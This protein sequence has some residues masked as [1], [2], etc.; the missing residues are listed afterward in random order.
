MSIEAAQQ[1]IGAPTFGSDAQ[2][3]QTF[4]GLRDGLYRLG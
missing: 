3:L 1:T 4:S 2:Q